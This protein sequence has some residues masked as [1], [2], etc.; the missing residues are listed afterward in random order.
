MMI[1]SL[2]VVLLL[3]ASAIAYEQEGNVLVLHDAD[4]PKV[5]EEFDYIMIEFYAPW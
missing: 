1:K 3:T 5:L 2:F 4:F